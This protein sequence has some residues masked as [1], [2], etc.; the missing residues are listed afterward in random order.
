MRAA[1]RIARSNDIYGDSNFT[2]GCTFS[3]DGLCVLTCTA[4]DNQLRLYNTPIITPLKNN[5]EKEEKT[6]KET[7]SS[8]RSEETTTTTIVTTSQNSNESQQQQQH[9]EEEE[10]VV[11]NEQ[12]EAAIVEDDGIVVQE[13]RTALSA[14]AGDSV[15]SYAWY[16]LMNSY[17]PA[18][19][20]FIST[21][22][23][24]PIHLYDAYNGSIRGSYRP[25]NGLDEMES[26]NVLTF[27]PDGNRI[28]ASGFKTDRTIH[29]F[30]T[31]IPGRT[32]D[33]WRLGKTKRSRD[34][35]KGLVSAI[36]FPT[37]ADNIFAVG[38]YSPGSI[39][40]YDDRSSS[41]EATLVLPNGVCLVG[42][43]KAHSRKKKHFTTTTNMEADDNNDTLNNTED[44]FSKAKVQ[45]YQS[46]CKGG[47]T[48]LLF[49]DHLLFSASRHSDVVLAWDLRML[50]GIAAYPRDGD[51]NQKLEFDINESGTEIYVASQDCSVKMYNVQTGSLQH[52]LSNFCDAVNGVSYHNNNSS[53]DELL[54]V[55]VG[56]RRFNE[57]YNDD[58]DESDKEVIL[59]NTSIPPGTLELFHLEKKK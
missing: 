12:E 41:P 24:Q 28:F 18:T 57:T 13:W 31:N 37:N 45:W 15:R 6:L 21:S 7:Q 34:G 26:P 30:N 39:Y 2:K 3:P 51:T 1:K 49:H 9:E 4:F 20:A 52:C 25:Y 42:H 40:I 56:A 33:I 47:I 17:D 35:Q 55:S 58:D 36:A 23:D 38:T 43:G 19:C 5:E 48:Q 22:R 44:M 10:V 54:A 16:P 50:K 8:S 53:G 11:G 46:R 59:D 27:T 14:S 29:V 32:S